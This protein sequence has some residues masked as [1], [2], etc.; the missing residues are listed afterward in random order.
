MTVRLGL[1]G[2]AA[3]LTLVRSAGAQAETIYL[4]ET[5]VLAPAPSYVYTAPAFGAPGYVVTGLPR[6]W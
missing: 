6:R 1:F 3:A 4:N 2:C 5:D